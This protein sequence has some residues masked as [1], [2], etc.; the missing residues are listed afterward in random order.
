MMYL[1]ER[2]KQKSCIIKSE[3]EKGTDIASMCALS[4]WK[5]IKSV[6]FI[7]EYFYCYFVVK[8]RDCI[9]LDCIMSWE[10]SGRFS[11]F[12]SMN[13]NSLVGEVFVFLCRNLFFGSLF[14]S[15]LLS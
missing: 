3:E 11:S 14:E 8:R 1:V 2:L 4:Q 15:F 9:S 6:L 13:V 12:N 5:S 7:K 10:L